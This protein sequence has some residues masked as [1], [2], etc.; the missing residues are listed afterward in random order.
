MNITTVR[1][2]PKGETITSTEVGRTRWAGSYY[3]EV[4]PS[5]VEVVTYS[6]VS[7]QRPSLYDTFVVEVNGADGF[8]GFA[9]HLEPSGLP[10]RLTGLVPVP[11]D[12]CELLDALDAA[13]DE[14]LTVPV[15][16]ACS[17]GCVNTLHVSPAVADAW[18]ALDGRGDVVR[19]GL[20]RAEAE[21]LL[22]ARRVAS[23]APERQG[24]AVS[25]T[26]RPASGPGALSG[27]EV[28]CSCG[29]VQTS[30]LFSVAAELGNA[31]LAWH[32]R[33]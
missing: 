14:P 30:S 28:R 16:V 24:P 23:I 19:T 15:T 3:G 10:P 25:V 7:D 27:Y 22:A 12:G 8:S 9:S 4:G 33:P 20:A 5:L 2:S 32:A 21:S 29:D 31:H 1:T 18:L 13:G 17:D 26:P 6:H 11:A